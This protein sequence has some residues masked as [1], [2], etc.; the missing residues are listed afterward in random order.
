MFCPGPTHGHGY[1]TGT[2]GDEFL[3]GGER[4]MAVAIGGCGVGFEDGVVG[5]AVVHG[6]GAEDGGAE[7]GCCCSKPWVVDVSALV[8]DDVDNA[9]EGE[10]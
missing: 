9:L 10:G 2:D 1:G 4:N 6:L 7:V 8:E 5:I 3:E